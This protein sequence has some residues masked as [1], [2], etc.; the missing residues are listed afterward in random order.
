M[1]QTCADREDKRWR[2]HKLYAIPIEYGERDAQGH[3]F[4]LPVV[5][6]RRLSRPRRCIPHSVKRAKKLLYR[7]FRKTEE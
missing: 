2:E 7:I 4:G 6:S 1:C 5:V 3:E